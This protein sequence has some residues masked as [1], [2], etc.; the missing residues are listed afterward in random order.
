MI[1][2]SSSIENV[3]RQ[4]RVTVMAHVPAAQEGVKAIVGRR[5]EFVDRLCCDDEVDHLEE[6]IDQITGQTLR[7]ARL[8]EPPKRLV[9]DALDLHEWKVSLYTRNVK[10]RF[11]LVPW[12]GGKLRVLPTLLRMGMR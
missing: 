2:P 5:S 3:I 1:E 7:L 11:T 4:L 6:P 8:D 12:A 10:V 9:L